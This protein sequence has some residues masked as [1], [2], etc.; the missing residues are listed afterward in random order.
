MDE[1]IKLYSLAK[2]IAKQLIS[3]VSVICYM[4]IMAYVMSFVM[5]ML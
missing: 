3:A 1:K 2:Y 4:H 5:M